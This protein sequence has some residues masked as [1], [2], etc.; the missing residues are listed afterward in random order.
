MIDE[1]RGQ[2]Y[3]G[4]YGDLSEP[5]QKAFREWATQQGFAD[6][7]AKGIPPRGR[8]LDFYRF[9][10]FRLET[11]PRFVK[12]AVA[13]TPVAGIPV[14]PGNGNIGPETMNHSSFW[15]PA[16]ARQGLVSASWSYDSPAGAKAHA[17]TIRMAAEWGGT[18][19]CWPP[20]W[21]DPVRELP[22]VTAHISALCDRVC[23]WHFGGALNGPNR[24]GWMALA[25]Q[26]ARLTHAT[27]GLEHTPPLYV[28][29]PDSIAYNDLVEM[30]TAEADAWRS[31]QQ[32]L[33]AANVDYG[34]TNR[35]A[36]PAGSVVLYACARP[37]L[38]RTEVAALSAFLGAGGRLLVTFTGAPEGPD[39]AP[40]D[41]WA[42]VTRSKVEHVE[43]RPEALRA[44]VDALCGLRNWLPD[45]TAVKTYLYRHGAGQRPGRVHLLSN[46][47]TEHVNE[48]VLPLAMVDRLTGSALPASHRLA[49]PPGHYA[50]LEEAL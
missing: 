15:P 6:L 3:S 24:S 47:D 49:L 20:S 32:A 36:V 48:V 46:T 30:N 38:D 27:N 35:L 8:T 22:I 9:Y 50:L 44:K 42:E 39:G 16:V 29:C 10:Q 45:A 23:H 19:F 2:W 31:L 1:P 18:S 25:F 11:V 21:R 37:V 5:S 33:F 34:V 17:E 4:G 12:A 26:A 40:V 41:E 14:M 43:L 13:G 28:W 7:A